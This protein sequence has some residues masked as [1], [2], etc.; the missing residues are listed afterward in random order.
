[1]VEAKHREL[2]SYAPLTWTYLTLH[3]S[4]TALLV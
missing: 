3:V 4:Q 1:M 2:L